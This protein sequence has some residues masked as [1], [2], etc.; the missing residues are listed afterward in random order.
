MRPAERAKKFRT[1]NP[2]KA[3]EIARR[4]RKSHP[5]KVKAAKDRYRKKHGEVF[6]AKERERWKK[7][8]K[9]DSEHTSR[10]RNLTE[11]QRA[12]RTENQ[13]IKHSLSCR[14]NMTVR[15]AGT[16][17]AEKSRK[18]VGCDIQF[19]RGYLEARFAPGMTWKN[20]GKWH[21]DHHI[22]CAEFDLRDPD[23]QRQAF[24][25]S[26][27]RPLWAHDNH[28]KHAIPPPT[29]QAELI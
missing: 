10:P 20:Y 8:R 5:A 15:S 17:K 14:I 25:Y 13:R 23:Q 18:L 3:R 28:R 2:D 6:L 27:L 9:S 22:P 24:H 4:W 19:L 29:H 12:E 7:Y 1:C 16:R 21:I 11:E 26:N